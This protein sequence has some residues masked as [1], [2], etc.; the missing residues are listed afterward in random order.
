MVESPGHGCRTAYRGRLNRY[1]LDTFNLLSYKTQFFNCSV[2]TDG[3]NINGL[4]R[5]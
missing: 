3:N 5:L 4:I 1:L 2:L